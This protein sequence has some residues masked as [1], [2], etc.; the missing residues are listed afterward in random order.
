MAEF[1]VTSEAAGQK[2]TIK[3][4]L[5]NSKL[6]MPLIIVSSFHFVQQMSGINA[7]GRPKH[8]KCLTMDN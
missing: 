6:K 2:I 3:E 5:C 8:N 4:V 7:V 1:E